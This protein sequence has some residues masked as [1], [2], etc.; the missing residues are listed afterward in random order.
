MFVRLGE[1]LAAEGFTAIRFSFRGHG[2]SGGATEGVTIAGEMLDIQAVIAHAI[3]EAPVPITLVAASFGAVPVALMLPAL[4]KQIS[5]LV[6]W[7]PV[8]D[9]DHTFVHPQLPWGTE[10]FGPDQ[11]LQLHEQGRLL[12][13]GEFPIGQVLWR[14]FTRYEPLKEFNRSH[15]PA[16][17]IHG[18]QDSYVSYEIARSAA[19]ARPNTEFRTIEG[20]DHGFDSREREDE[21][22]GHTLKWLTSGGAA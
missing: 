3:E 6:L 1:R 4:E 19:E 10:N 16:L 2:E 15:T 5:S 22:I 20:S 13:D 9:L 21:A 14:E 11:Q 18:D 7:N 8:L 17:V 12:I